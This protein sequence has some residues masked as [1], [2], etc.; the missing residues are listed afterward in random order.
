MF[1][2]GTRER[3]PREVALGSHRRAGQGK[4]EG[5]CWG[6]PPEIWDHQAAHDRQAWGSHL[7]L[8]MGLVCLPETPWERMVV[9]CFL[10]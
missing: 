7:R 8:E 1:D 5:E 10:E 6:G 2:K 3:Q 9:R 4:A